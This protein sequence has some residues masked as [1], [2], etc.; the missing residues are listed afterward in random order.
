LTSKKYY[1]IPKSEINSR[2]LKL[3]DILKKKEFEAALLLSIPELYY[4]SGFGGDGAIYIPV[5][6]NPVHLVRRNLHLA[7]NYSQIPDIQLYGKRSKIFDTLKVPSRFR[8]AIEKNILPYSS[9]K[10]LESVAKNIELV[11]GS[12]IFRSIRSVKSKF[13]INQIER[14]ASLVDKSF[15]YCTE[16]ADSQMTEIELATKL[17]SWLLNNGHNGFITTYGFNTALL[18]YSYVI[19]SLSST[20]NIHF[21]PISGYGLSLKYPFG[22]S[23]QKLE[24]N[25]PFMVDTCG[26][27]LGYISDTTRTFICGRFDEKTREQ[28]NALIQIKEFLKHSLKPKINLGNLYNEVLDL[29]SLFSIRNFLVLRIPTL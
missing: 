7:Q 29:S 11:N 18:N 25:R 17:D 10:F 14:A 12:L 5:D 1:T 26:N 8:V 23:R 2:I 4:Y 22:P 3:K 19:S 13:E 21:T 27:H 16:I 9:V 6:G 28:L 20:L 15:E 24:K